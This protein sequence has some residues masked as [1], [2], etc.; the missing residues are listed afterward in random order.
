MAIDYAAIRDALVSVAQA[1]G[2]FDA[3]N[4]HEPKSAPGTGLYCHVFTAGLTPI[5][6]G[7]LNSTTVRLQ[8]T[9]QVRCSMTR[10]PEDGID[11][12]C[13]QA[14]DALLAD[15]SGNF[16]LEI[17]GVRHVDLLGAYGDPLMWVAGYVEQDSVVYRVYDVQVPIIVDSAFSQAA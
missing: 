14:A 12:D 3:V 4:A 9:M 1:S 15:L 13:A 17:S 6:A 8:W 11:V 5:R 10:E 16:N 7:G 2:Y